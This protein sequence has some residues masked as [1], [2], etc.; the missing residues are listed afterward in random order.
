[1]ALDSSGIVYSW[2]YG[3]NGRLGHG[4]NENQIKPKIIEHLTTANE[5]FKAKA[6]KI[7]C[8]WNYSLIV[9]NKG[10]IWTWGYGKDNELGID[11]TDDSAIPKR[12]NSWTLT[13]KSKH[14]ANDCDFV[15]ISDIACGS[16]HV[17]ALSGIFIIV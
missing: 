10:Y 3:G 15:Q 7:G 2:G 4:D 6:K 13:K 11:S 8:G 9:D 17:L 5:K 16:K 14:I 12:I 1:M